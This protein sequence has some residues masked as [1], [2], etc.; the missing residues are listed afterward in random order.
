MCALPISVSALRV[1][2]Q[3]GVR[4]AAAVNLAAAG[5]RRALSPVLPSP[6]Q[7]VTGP[8]R[9]AGQLMPGRQILVFCGHE[10]LLFGAKV[11]HHLQ[12]R[13]EEHTSELQSLMRI[14]SAVFFL[15]KKKKQQQT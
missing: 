11:A 1:A 3:V 8:A 14:S 10:R 2:A 12:M 5:F 13:S 15:K 4:C 9:I 6:V 7:R